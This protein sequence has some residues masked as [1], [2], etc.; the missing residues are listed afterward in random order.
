MKSN[1]G[2]LGCLSLTRLYVDHF[3][4]VRR[5]FFLFLPTTSFHTVCDIFEHSF[6]K[7]KRRVL[8][9]STLAMVTFGFFIIHHLRLKHPPLLI[10]I[11]FSFSLSDKILPGV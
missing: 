8:R 4:V 5:P 1:S 3:S 7:H 9:K 10:L 2:G 6:G 11:L